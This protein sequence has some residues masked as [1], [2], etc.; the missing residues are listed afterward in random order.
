V[1]PRPEPVAGGISNVVGGSVTGQIATGHDI[2]QTTV[3]GVLI[4]V[5]AGA[6]LPAPE[7]RPRPVSLRPRDFSG[8]I[9][10]TRELELV[11]RGLATGEPVAFHGPAGMGKTA[12]L[13]HVAYRSSLPDGVV[14]LDRRRRP[15]EDVVQELWDAFWTATVQRKVSE[16]EARH[17]LADVRALIL[18][19]D[20]D[21][22]SDELDA[23][24]DLAPGCGVI[25]ASAEPCYHG[26]G[27]SRALGRL[28]DAEA[29]AVLERDLPG[30]TADA[31]PAAERLAAA[32]AGRPGAI[33]QAALAAAEV[34]EHLEDVAA[35]LE[36]P[37]QA[38]LASLEDS[39]LEILCVLDAFD[40]AA[41]PG[42]LVVEL[43]GH[44]DAWDRLD[45]LVQRG[46]AE[47]HSPRFTSAA[48]R[49]ERALPG[50][51]DRLAG[52]AADW[53]ERHADEIVDGAE[54]LVVAA[55]RGRDPRAVVR[56]ARAADRALVLGARWG[57]W[58]ALLVAALE[59]AR[60][61]GDRAGEA[62][63]L[64]QLGSRALLAGQAEAAREQLERALELREQ[65]GDEVGAAVTRHNLG[66][67]PPP[68]PPNGNGTTPSG[69]RWPLIAAAVAAVALTVATAVAVLGSS[70]DDGASHGNTPTPTPTKTPGPRLTV[71]RIDGPK[72]RDVGQKGH[73]TVRVRATG[74]QKVSYRW[75]LE[76]DGAA[77]ESDRSAQAADVVFDAA[78][79]VKLGVTVTAGDKKRTRDIGIT[80]PQPPAGD[81]ADGDG[82]MTPADCNDRDAKI[83]PG[84]HDTPDNNVDEDCDGEDATSPK[85]VDADGDDYFT[86]DDC[87]DDNPRINPGAR[88]IAGNEVDE[89]CDGVVEPADV[90][91]DQ[92]HYK[93]S[94]DCDDGNAKINPGATDVPDN[95]IDENCDGQDATNLRSTG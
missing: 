64:H 42:E 12:L 54:A 6:E 34:G 51:D 3:H 56:L 48:P 87:D 76:G 79:S 47:A 31:R 15:L 27:A 33:R 93:K 81:D 84:A 29:L 19:D 17:A 68:P 60:A 94:Q 78:G 24:V 7:P 52:A 82:Y 38:V 71:G 92:D 16:T 55:Q 1:T 61:A 80:V 72:D 67:P 46:L 62:W 32:L 2:V 37:G 90:D 10:R 86:P 5:E 57:A 20:A 89:N 11:D 14:Y 53:A 36:A 40:G 95:G 83:H 59:A 70:D 44:A 26:P 69:P 8:L 43:S 66:R 41:V 88:E 58:R 74:G 30:L 9:G 21:G 45:A 73:Y 65:L 77:F 23:L 91:A 63:A 4:Q 39:Y 49:V 28:S 50:L 75:T 35:R 18:V 25:L 13:R 22:P 85:P